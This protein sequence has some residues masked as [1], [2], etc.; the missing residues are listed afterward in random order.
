MRSKFCWFMLVQLIKATKFFEM[1][2]EAFRA[3]S[4]ELPDV[5]VC[6]QSVA[7]WHFIITL[8]DFSSPR[9]KTNHKTVLL[10]S[11][12]KHNGTYFQTYNYELRRTWH[13]AVHGDDMWNVVKTLNFLICGDFYLKNNIKNR[14]RKM[15][16]GNYFVPSH[17]SSKID[18]HDKVLITKWE[19]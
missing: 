13:G 1:R 10:F 16:V 4:A 5:F 18:H 2:K 8:F 17:V 9:A 12:E 7:F 14:L 11:L 6:N 3:P 15:Y 19:K